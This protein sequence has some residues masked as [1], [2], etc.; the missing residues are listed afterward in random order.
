MSFKKKLIFGLIFLFIYFHVEIGFSAENKNEKPNIV[1][2]LADDMGWGD[3]R[4]NG[5]LSIE[6]PVLDRLAEKSLSFD[7]FYVCPLCAP[8]RAE[9]LTG[10][11]FLRT[12]VSSVTQGYENM[13]PRETTFAEILKQNGYAT[14][15]FGKWH[16][17]GYFLQHP[18]RKGFDEYIGFMVGHLGYYY[19]AIY[20]HNDED[21]KSDGYATDYFTSQALG[22]IERNADKPFLCYVPYNV[23]HSP[24]QVPEK[25][26]NKYKTRGLDNELAT[27]YGMV[28]NMDENIGLI[29]EKLDQLNLTEKTIVIFLS[30]N[31]PN[32]FRYNG[33]M[34]GKK[35]NVDEGGVRVPFYISWPGTI[36]TGTTTQ[37]AQGID[38]F[39]TLLKLCSI[40]YKPVLPIDGVD[41]SK[42]IFKKAE[43]FDRYIYTRQPQYPLQ[44]RAGS[45]RN[46][47]HRLT[48]ANGETLLYDMQNDPSQKVNIAADF[49]EIKNKLTAEYKKW[50]T[51][52]V[53]NYQL[54]T[55]IVAGFDKEQRITLPVQDAI[56][57]G[58]VK[59]SSIHPNQSHTENWV[60]NGDSI[61][62]KLNMQQPGKYRVEMQYGCPETDT[63]SKFLFHSNASSFTFTIDKAFDSEILPNRDYVPRTESV[64]RTWEWMP[65]GTISLNA[66]Q[67]KLTLK[68]T[69]KNKNEAGLIKAIR[70]IKI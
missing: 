16:N 8:T 63:G 60:E 21:I 70:L 52:M 15:C 45:I 6:T 17:G 18:N 58:K 65:I 14:G 28:E 25:Y 39:P 62:W 40:S 51:E 7:R 29:Q 19:D 43:N 32:T 59:Y 22:F 69:N 13:N 48:I 54:Q 42:T 30:D 23:P 12:G 27:I 4:S 37:L 34:K 67:E 20:Q 24:F 49:P 50:E 53:D 1:L 68:L 57:S 10:R 5:N 3:I 9:I 61:Y 41:L 56:L 26:F 31:G 47:R 64:E 11:Y 46:N 2:I 33:G 38:L 66:G 55:T 44:N 36:E 35:G